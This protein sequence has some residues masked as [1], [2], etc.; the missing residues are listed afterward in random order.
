MVKNT[1]NTP[2]TKKNLK[3]IHTQ[4]SITMEVKGFIYCSLRNS[5]N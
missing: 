5:R 2:K 3:S 4:N 1:E